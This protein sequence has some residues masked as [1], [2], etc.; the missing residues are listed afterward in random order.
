MGSSGD[1][2]R[3]LDE[4]VAEGDGI[5]GKVLDLKGEALCCGANVEVDKRQMKV[6]VY[7][8]RKEVVDSFTIKAKRKSSPRD[9]RREQTFHP[10]T[11]VGAGAGI[12][13]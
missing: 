1:K 10:S 6:T 9:N 7:N 13:F 5:H 3:A 8:Q 12:N 4:S 2:R 11:F